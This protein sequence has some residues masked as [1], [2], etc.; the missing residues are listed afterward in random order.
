MDGAAARGRLDILEWLYINRTEGCSSAAFTGAVTGGHLE[1]LKWL[2][3]LYP[4]LRHP[5]KEIVMAAVS[6]QMVVVEFLCTRLRSSEIELALEVAAAYGHV[7]VVESLVPGS[8]I[9]S[10]AFAA[11]AAHGRE[12]VVKL[13]L[14]NGCS[15][16]LVYINPA[17]KQAAKAGHTGI[18][19]L[20]IGMCDADAIG[21]A[22]TAVA[23][24][25]RINV[26]KLLLKECDPDTFDRVQSRKRVVEH[27]LVVH[28]IPVSTVIVSTG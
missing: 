25:N 11:A 12:G 3:N 16:N 18:I 24:D 15:D 2:Y 14:K 28:P 13:L 7:D 17:L 1:V 4:E 20:L 6:G 23:V 21:E 19:R 5:A 22:L 8:F 27:I 26:M 9:T 10:R